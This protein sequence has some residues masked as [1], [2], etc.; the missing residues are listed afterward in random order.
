MRVLVTG[1]A[2]F[3]GHHLVMG[4]VALGH[5]VVVLDDLSTG[6]RARLPG[7]ARVVEGDLRQRAAVAEA[8]RNCEVVFHLAA[9]ASVAKSVDDP[10]T[11]NAVNVDGSLNLMIEAARSGVRRVVVASSSAVYG[12]DPRLP[13]RESDC[14]EPGS[15]Y[16][17]S[18]LAMEHYVHNLGASSGIETVALRYF[19]VYGPGQDP[20]AEYAAVVPRFVMAALDGRQPV[21][22]GDG[23]Q[24][25]DFAFVEDVVAANLAAATTPGISGLTA[26]I[27]SGRRHSLLDLLDAVGQAIGSPLAPVFHAPRHGDVRDS[28]ADIT[29]AGERLGY[30]PSFTLVDGLQRTLAS[31]RDGSV[32]GGR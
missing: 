28:Q 32:A 26:N 6:R 1:G 9:I 21:I 23:Y 5:E 11:T 25:R 19:N 13:S 16:A 20:E 31:Y 3:I 14:P 8:L 30:Q 2:G 29:L 15:P 18:K 7:A 27:G 17:T 12:G 4:L 24:S 22:Y 10:A